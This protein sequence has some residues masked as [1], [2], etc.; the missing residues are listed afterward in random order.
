L[1]LD[2]SYTHMH[3]DI[4]EQNYFKFGMEGVQYV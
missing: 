1:H 3:N 4:Y 2:I